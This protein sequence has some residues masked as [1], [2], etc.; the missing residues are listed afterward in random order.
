MIVY[1]MSCAG[2]HAF[3]GWFTSAEACEK[4]AAEGLLEC[5]S[6][7]SVEIRKLPSAPHVHTSGASVASG[8][9]L[10]EN[11][12]HESLLLLRK[13]ILAN[14]EDVGRKFAEVAR[15][16]HYQEEKARGIRGVVTPEEATELHEEGVAT[17]SIAP[18][19]IP[20]DEVH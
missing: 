1:Q 3:E 20:S 17:L 12:R 6:C 18:G 7:S 16:I 5:P 19:V 2:G 10:A 9:P 14:T 15:R 8:Q 4:Q 13:F 11:V